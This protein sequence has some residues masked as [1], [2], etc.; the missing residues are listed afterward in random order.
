[1]VILKMGRPN[2]IKAGGVILKQGE[3]K[4]HV[5]LSEGGCVE[6]GEKSNLKGKPTNPWK[7]RKRGQE[8]KRLLYVNILGNELLKGEDLR[9]GGP[10]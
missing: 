9:K 4:N 6:G 2:Q 10:Q 5:P 8:R 7:K 3:S 1:M